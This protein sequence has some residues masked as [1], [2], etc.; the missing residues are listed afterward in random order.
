MTEEKTPKIVNAKLTFVDQ[1]KAWH[2]N[3]L[4]QHYIDLFEQELLATKRP[5]IQD[6]L[7]DLKIPDCSGPNAYCFYDQPASTKFHGN[8]LGGLAKHCIAVFTHLNMF[9]TQFKLTMEKDSIAIV[10]LLHDLCKW[11]TYRPVVTLKGILSEGKTPFVVEDIIALGHGEES[12]I[13]IMEYIP[14]TPEEK[15]M[16][17]WHMG[18]YDFDYTWKNYQYKVKE[19]CPATIYLQLADQL[20][21]VSEGESDE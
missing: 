13:R 19:R 7:D 17:R 2:A 16:I 8:E 6:L 10:A 18:N 20:A 4:R 21:A 5:G 11:N 15:I 14:L 1:L 9:V 12:I 3:P